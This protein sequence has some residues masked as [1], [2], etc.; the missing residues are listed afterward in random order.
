VFPLVPRTSPVPPCVTLPDVFSSQELDQL[1]IVASTARETGGTT[2]VD[3][4]V[5]RSKVTWASFDAA[6]IWLYQ[7]VA[8]VVGGINAEHYRFDLAGIG[9]PIQLARYEA[10]DGGHYDWHQD[11]GVAQISRKLSVTAQLTDP[12]GYEGGDLQIMTASKVAEP[13]RT[14]GLIIVFPAYQLHRV[15]PVKRGTRHSLV[16]WASGP[17]FK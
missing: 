10:E 9:E 11:Y 5:R 16:A 4:T 8:E 6:N 14:R 1:E 3:A 15:T 7:R 17:A 2:G 13:G 12:D